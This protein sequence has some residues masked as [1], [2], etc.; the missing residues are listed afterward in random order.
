MSST[1]SRVRSDCVSIAP[2]IPDS[3]KSLFALAQIRII[4]LQ[5]EW[6]AGDYL[7]IIKT[8]STRDRVLDGHDLDRLLP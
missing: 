7:G 2:K 4:F 8:K 3:E 1:V 5:I 6:E